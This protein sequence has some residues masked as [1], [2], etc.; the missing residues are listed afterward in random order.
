MRSYDSMCIYI[1][2]YTEHIAYIH[3]HTFS[4]QSMTCSVELGF[5]ISGLGLRVLGSEIGCLP[6]LALSL[7][8]PASTMR[9]ASSRCPISHAM[10]RGVRDLGGFRNSGHLVGVGVLVIR[11]S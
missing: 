3:V 11:K 4:Y 7:S 5:R 2:I 1:Y 8:A 6:K 10:R 9:R